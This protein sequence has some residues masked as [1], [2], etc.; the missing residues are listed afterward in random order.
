MKTNR[1]VSKG[2]PLRLVVYTV[3]IGDKES[4]GNPL[5]ILPEEA[6]SDLE[7]DYV[8]ITDNRL[9]KSDIWRFA[10]ID[11]TCLPPEKLSRRAKAMPH[12]YFP[13]HDISL[14]IDNTVAFKRL[15]T[16][17]DISLNGLA[18][19]FRVFRHP[20]RNHPGEEA[21]AIATLGYESVP[22]L[23]EQLDFYATQQP[24]ETITPL[25]TCTVILRS[26]HHPSVIRQGVTWW[27]Q[28]LCFSKRDQMSFDFAVRQSGCEIGYFPGFKH[29][30]DLILWMVDSNTPRVAAS[31]DS[32]RYAWIHRQDSEAVLNP[33]AHFLK[34]GSVN[35]PLYARQ[36]DLL[37]YICYM[38]RSSLGDQ[39]A[40]RRQVAGPLG[41]A[42]SSR[43][44]QTGRMLLVWVSDASRA[45]GMLHEEFVLAAPSLATFLPGFQA[46]TLEIS[47]EALS[48]LTPGVPGEILFDVIVVFGNSP[49]RLI[50]LAAMLTR[51]ASPA[52]GGL[53]TLSN[54]AGTIDDIGLARDR[55][56]AQF[57]AVCEVSVT[58]SAHD[59]VN[60]PVANSL[61]FFEWKGNA[62]GARSGGFSA[63]LD[64]A[65]ASIIRLNLGSNQRL[66]GYINIGL[67]IE[68]GGV[69]D[70]N[71]NIR[72]L[73]QFDDNCVDEIIAIH[74]IQHCWRWEIVDIL[75]EWVRVL[76]PGGKLVLECPNLLSA[77]EA[78]LQ[79]R[80]EA[81]DSAQNSDKAAWRF[82]GDPSSE[83]PRESFRWLYTPQSLAQ[84]ML[85]I[86]LQDLEQT[87]P[88]FG[89]GH[90]AD[91]RIEGTKPAAIRAV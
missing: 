21:G 2:K 55:I 64:N 83:S 48:Q 34:N 77:G 12:E 91:M 58:S 23:C 13:A 73:D 10:Y 17:A 46:Q 18:Y 7:I 19:L 72:S 52:A 9:L 85:S 1:Q 24:I 60:G 8:C 43:R 50:N 3:L 59:S 11:S 57:K 54:A 71:S 70:A 42:L 27:E 81:S 49:D 25:S 41:A 30:N 78:L 4:L 36:K 31:F 22:V 61:V 51:F 87:P 6:V 82:Y 88:R 90:P 15:P 86:G 53:V 63:G 68:G 32:K 80:A 16:S 35:G 45:T 29:D 5:G 14:Y 74:A 28:I 75:R 38:H 39:I 47:A 62:V 33:K 65:D 76:K 20:T 89:A 56:A 66:S 40:P 67:S 37:N 44:E 69:S 79:N 26:H 84:I